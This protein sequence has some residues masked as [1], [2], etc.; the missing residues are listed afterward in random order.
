MKQKKISKSD[1]Q[2]LKNIPSS[3]KVVDGI[4]HCFSDYEA[5]LA[6]QLYFFVKIDRNLFCQL[7]R[8]MNMPEEEPSAFDEFSSNDAIML[9][10]QVIKLGGVFSN[11]FHIKWSF[12]AG[13]G[14]AISKKVDFGVSCVA[15]I[16]DLEEELINFFNAKYHPVNEDSET[17]ITHYLE[18]C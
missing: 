2:V 14:I 9:C 16:H 15:S 7:W 13:E 3:L 11:F 1:I 18:R 10:I 5:G 12:N 17:V 8:H 6:G 4:E